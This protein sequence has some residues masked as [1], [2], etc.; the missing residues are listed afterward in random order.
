MS[1]GV[2]SDAR[3]HR[4]QKVGYDRLLM[5][6]LPGGCIAR[7]APRRGVSGGVSGIRGGIWQAEGSKGRR[8]NA[9]L[10]AVPPLAPKIILRAPLR[11][12]RPRET[13]DGRCITGMMNDPQ[14]A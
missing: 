13:Q 1:A 4:I 2:R 5:R 3:H 6:A 11:E 9:A 8:R 14:V 10:V 12:K 7:R